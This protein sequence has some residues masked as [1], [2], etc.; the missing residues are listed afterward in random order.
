[1]QAFD[2]GRGHLLL[3][4]EQSRAE[5]AFVVKASVQLLETLPDVLDRDCGLG[6]EAIA[7]VEA[8]LDALR[9]N[10]YAALMGDEP[11]PEI[12]VE[13][14]AGDTIDVPEKPPPPQVDMFDSR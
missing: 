1:V 7:R 4:V 5:L 14:V 8:A 13:G 6:H 10:L 9:E 3:P 11:V 12:A 2:D